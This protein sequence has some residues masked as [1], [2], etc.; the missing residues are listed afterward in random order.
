MSCI[1][2]TKFVTKFQRTTLTAW[3]FYMYP[4]FNEIFF[5]LAITGNS[6][7]QAKRTLKKTKKFYV[8]LIN[9]KNYYKSTISLTWYNST[10]ICTCTKC[11][12]SKDA[13]E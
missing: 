10:C 7:S 5:F 4:S 9:K 1:G 2:Y 11:T 12:V 8:K 3:F 13:F 6:F